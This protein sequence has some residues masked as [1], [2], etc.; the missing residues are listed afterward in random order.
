MEVLLKEECQG[1]VTWTAQCLDF[2]KGI[3]QRGLLQLRGSQG[4]QRGI[5]CCKNNKEE[6]VFWYPDCEVG[7][8]VEGCF[9]TYHTKL[10]YEGKMCFIY[11]NLSV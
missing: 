5:V 10:N 3:S 6:T 11:K 4:Q 2:L 9:K 7:L 8:Y 1:D